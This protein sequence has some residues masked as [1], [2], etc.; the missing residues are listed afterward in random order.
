M[1]FL[2]SLSA[3]T[4]RAGIILP[5]TPLDA[6]AFQVRTIRSAK[7]NCMHL[8]VHPVEGASSLHRTNT[9]LGRACVENALND[10][11]VTYG[12]WRDF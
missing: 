4:H 2:L 9:N 8:S 5:V 1:K 11:S 6:P 3:L 12:M 7:Q 10:K